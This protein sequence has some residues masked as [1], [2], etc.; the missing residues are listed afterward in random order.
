MT[1]ADPGRHGTRVTRVRVVV[2]YLEPVPLKS[3]RLPV[4]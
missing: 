2:A 4:T 3:T 1:G